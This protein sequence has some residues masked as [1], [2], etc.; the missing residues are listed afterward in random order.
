M[1]RSFRPIVVL[2]L[3]ALVL[4]MVTALGT[5]TSRAQAATRP[6]IVMVLADDMRASDYQVM[7]QTNR[8]LGK[9]GTTFPNFFLTTPVCCPSRSTILTGRYAHNHGVLRNSGPGGGWQTFHNNG[10]DQRTVAVRLNQAG[11]R[12]GL[13]GKYLN[14]Y[15]FEQGHVPSGWDQWFATSALDYYDYT[16]NENGQP[17]RYGSGGSD[18]LTDVLARKVA[19]FI[20]ETPRR[21]PLFAYISVKA[22]HGPAT[23][24]H[25]YRGDCDGM[26]VERNASFN[27]RDIGDKPGYMQDQRLTVQQVHAIDALE[28]RRLC[29]LK[30]VD[31]LVVKVVGALETAGRLDN[32]YIFFASDNGFLMG[33]HRRVSKDVP[34]EEAIRVPL[35]VRGPGFEPGVTDERLVGNLDLP[36]TWAAIG[37]TKMPEPDGRNLL[38]DWQRD[39]ILIETFGRDA[40]D[41][42]S[43]PLIGDPKPV[44]PY[45]AI[46]TADA[47]YVEYEGGAKEYYDL[48]ADPLQLQNL[49]R[50]VDTSDLEARLAL[51]KRCR[52]SGC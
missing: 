32:T 37:G 5:P 23:V 28:A 1:T 48:V 41:T 45:A 8:L 31:D 35:L 10:N 38:D 51:L 14:G 6:N 16:L 40:G 34:Y 29:S 2:G 18:Y 24:A 50:T 43:G 13:F 27:E 36:P 11:Y 9:L 22:P 17:R 3:L 7:T 44:P 52:A 4:P 42:D 49:A 20:K 26:T 39:A 47:I 33:H 46:R 21:S 19:A 25:K 30:S 15:V 12:T